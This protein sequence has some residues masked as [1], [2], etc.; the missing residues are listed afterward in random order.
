M[1]EARGKH[2]VDGP[3]RQ[4]SCCLIVV[5]YLFLCSNAD[6]PKGLGVERLDSFPG[7]FLPEIAVKGNLDWPRY[8]SLCHIVCRKLDRNVVDQ[9]KLTQQF[10]APKGLQSTVTAENLSGNCDGIAAACPPSCLPL[11]EASKLLY[12]WEP[13]ESQQKKSSNLGKSLC[14][15]R[16]WEDDSPNLQNRTT[17]LRRL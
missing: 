13:R 17:W 4:V 5:I 9:K 16:A 10:A 14:H 6:A 2:R 12:P 1:I 8:E 15:E 11:D 3:P 7:H